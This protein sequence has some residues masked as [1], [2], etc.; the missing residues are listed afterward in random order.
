MGDLDVAG[1]INLWIVLKNIDMSHKHLFTAIAGNIHIHKK[2]LE[3][4]VLGLVFF[5]DMIIATED[6]VA[7]DTSDWKHVLF[8]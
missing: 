2:S 1:W 4:I 8:L 6:L 3:V 5:K 7:R